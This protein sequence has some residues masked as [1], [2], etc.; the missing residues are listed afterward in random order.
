MK[1]PN[2]SFDE[3]QKFGVE[4]LDP[5]GPDLICKSCGIGWTPRKRGRQRKLMSGWWLCPLG[6][7]DPSTSERG[8]IRL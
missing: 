8:S 4:L 3:L 2:L 5:A 7:N 6:C 1:K